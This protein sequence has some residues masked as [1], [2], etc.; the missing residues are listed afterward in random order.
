M[1]V[2]VD[3]NL[4]KQVHYIVESIASSD[5]QQ[6][7]TRSHR[8]GVKVWDGP[9]KPTRL[10]FEAQLIRRSKIDGGPGFALEIGF[11]AEERSVELNQRAIDHL[12]SV[13]A[14][15]RPILG[16]EAVAGSFF[17]ADQWRRISDVW[18]EPDL[19][20]D[21]TPFEIASRLV[22]YVDALGPHLVGRPFDR[23]T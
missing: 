14:E 19:D 12:L 23:S 15:W 13:E 18:F 2:I 17:D 7:Q 3:P 10:H 1:A 20:A 21:D 22:D 6:L 4:F 8:Y 16:S 5:H 11:H 9:Q